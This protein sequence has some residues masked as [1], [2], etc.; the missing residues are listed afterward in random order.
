MGFEPLEDRRLLAVTTTYELLTLVQDLDLTQGPS[1][2]HANA[3]S[4]A[5]GGI[6]VSGSHGLHT[7]LDIFNDDLSDAGG[8]NNLDGTNASI[9]QLANGNLVIV[10]QDANSILYT[11]RNGFGAEVVA[12]TDLGDPNSSNP[13]VAALIDGTFVIVNQDLFG[14]TDSNIDVRVRSSTGS[15]ILGF[16]I[17]TTN[18]F[19]TNAR[20]AGLDDGGFAVA[21]QRTI[22]AS[23]EIW[24]AVYESTGIIRKS[25]ALA[26]TVGT[27]NRHVDVSSKSGGFALVYEDNGWGTGTID[28]S[29]AEFNS[30]GTRQSFANISSPLLSNDGSDDANPTV[31]RLINDLLVVGFE[32]NSFVSNTDSFVALFD[33]N[34]NKVLS[35]N[36]INGW[37]SSA[38]DVGDITIAGSAFG[39]INVFHTNYTDGDVDG[40]IRVGRRTSVGGGGNDLIVGDDFIDIMYGNGGNDTLEG[41]GGQD[42]LDGGSGDDFLNGGLDS[43][44]MLGG[45][46]NDTFFID[47]LSPNELDTLTELVGEGTDTLDFGSL[48]TDVNINFGS[49]EVQG[50]HGNRRIK[51]NSHESFEN[52]TGG[53]GNDRFVGNSLNNT[54]VGNVGDDFLYGESGNDSLIGGLGNDDYAFSAASTVEVDSLTE[55][56]GEG[57]DRVNF[58]G[59]F[60]DVNVNLGTVATQQVHTNRL[61]S[62]NLDNTF[63]D[64]WGGHANDTLVG[65]SASNKLTSFD[66]NDTLIGGQGSDTL[67]GGNG[68]DN[69]A[70]QTAVAAEFDN[71]TE[72]INQGID[73]L[74]F[75]A[76]ST[77]VTVNLGTVGPQLVQSD[78]SI[79][80]NLNNT[81]ENAKGGSA[82]DTLTG[83]S[84]SNK[85]TGNAGNDRLNGGSG[86]DNLV[87][88]L[89]DDVYAF[90]AASTGE[91]DTLTELAGQ[92]TDTL[93]FA[94][95]SSEVTVNLATLGPQLVHMDRSILLNAGTTFENATGGSAADTLTGNTGANTLIGNAGNDRLNGGGGNDNLKGGPGD[96]T[97]AFGPA[98]SGEVDT[99]NELINQGTDTLTFAAIS[100]DVSINL[101]T[102][103]PQAVHSFRSIS[104]NSGTDF[105]NVTGGSA[106]D[107]LTGNSSDNTLI[108]NAGI[109]R[110]NGASGSDALR[111]GKGDDIYAFGTASANEIDTLT[112]LVD[113]GTDRL[114]FAAISIDVTVNLGAT[115][116]QLIHTDRSISLNS[117][118][119]FENAVG[120]SANDVIR[121]NN[122]NNELWGNAGDDLLIGLNGNDILSGGIGNDVLIGGRG[123]DEM[124]GNQDEDLLI[125]GFTRFGA[126]EDDPGFL[127]AVSTQWS[128]VGSFATRVAALTP[129]L[130]SGTTVINDSSSD[131]LQS[132]ADLN[133]DWL[134]ASQVDGVSKDSGDRL[135]TL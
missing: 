98:S 122:S 69:Y 100:T 12:S 6:A 119:T 115:T 38:D 116:P 8:A 72:Y 51:L 47:D 52:A 135:T 53:S 40:E 44:E 41:L 102:V 64:I 23:T 34:S 113:E 3:T 107:T 5:N 13:D 120:G 77:D 11:I 85:L 111:G 79:S 110:L 63:E 25:A 9:G 39:R 65:N 83:N 68:D 104:L 30:V 106:N 2:S 126:A 74:T 36:K 61:I 14:S 80:L 91:V 90:G 16:T 76:I 45:M 43:D 73:T 94:A 70:F 58:G 56:A 55:F 78:R 82:D 27:V 29:L 132:N 67:V 20:V 62:L 35:T 88:G 71:L 19:D 18:A 112:E 46:G 84:A 101:S 26:D 37:E 54:L 42:T 1:T 48:T 124:D 96:D 121:G 49:I 134:F 109:D 123:Q 118:S 81:F 57:T 7:D 21:W 131:T 22:G 50:I 127:Q 33:P 89:G 114:T 10:S 97:F 17:D 117:G 129:V 59:I 75:T 103:G 125:A 105:E 128:D 108:G 66:G 95:I 31:S 130:V 60:T 93:T 87:G 28:I 86:S 4:L 92:G 133:L 15:S 99:L 24:Y 32:D